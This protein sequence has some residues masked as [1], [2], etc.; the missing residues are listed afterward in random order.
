MYILFI[1]LCTLNN[2]ISIMC[3]IKFGKI[4]CWFFLTITT[5]NKRMKFTFEL[6]L[7]PIQQF[8]A[9]S[10]REQGNFQ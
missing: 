6:C 5:F 7:T 3:C 1:P 8:S 9:I 4:C 10:W 2:I